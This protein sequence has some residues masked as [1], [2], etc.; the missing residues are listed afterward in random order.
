MKK[1]LKHKIHR[2][3]KLLGFTLAE[4]MV[5]LGIVSFALVSGAGILS[6]AL[7]TS[8]T[9]R[10]KTA[11]IGIANEFVELYRN[12]P[13]DQ[14]GTTTGWPPGSIPTSQNISRSGLTFTASTRVDY[15]DDPF[16]GNAAG[17]IVG[18]PRD[19]TPNDYK[20]TEIKILSGSKI[21]TTLT[22]IIAPRGLESAPN[23]G[24]LL[25]QVFNASGQPVPE[26]TV[27]IA[28]SATTPLVN[29]ANTTD[30][31]G[32]LS[33]LSLP[34]S[35]Q[36][37]RI[38]VTKS[39]YTSDGTEQANGNGYTP[40]KPDLSIMIGEVTEAS[41]TID[42]TSS[43]VVKTV[44]QQCQSVSNKAFRL[45]SKKLRGSNPD[46]PKYDRNHD[47]GSNG[48]AALSDLE[49]DQY[50][51]E[52]NGAG[53]D[54]IAGKNPSV[55]QLPPGISQ[56]LTLV[57][58]PHSPHSL[59]MTVNDV[60]TGLPLTDASVTISNNND[61]P[62]TLITG[63][64][65]FIQADWSEGGNQALFSN[66]N[67]YWTKDQNIDDIATAGIL[68]LSKSTES[69]AYEESFASID[70]RDDGATTAAWDGSGI[71]ALPQNSGLYET[72]A[73]AQT[74]K[75]NSANGWV[76]N[77][78]VEATETL[79]GGTIRYSLSTDGGINFE[80]VNLDELHA[81]VLRGSDLRLRIELETPDTISTP[82]V[83]EV[84]VAYVLEQYQTPGTLESSTFDAGSQ[85]V[86]QGIQWDPANQIAEAGVSSVKFQVAANND[87]AAWNFLGPDGTNNSFYDAS[88]A[89]LLAALD[90][91]Q[92]LRYKAIL[93]TADER[94]SPTLSS[95]AI[96]YTSG[97]TPPGQVFFSGLRNDSYLI[98]ITK[99]GYLPYT[100]T[101]DVQSQTEQ[102]IPLTPEP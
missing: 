56:E 43:L 90:N 2:A 41:F 32:N 47:T 93:A 57:L 64:G 67:K 49:W 16:D 70:R 18:K 23:T 7:K 4:S 73:A 84:R 22:T 33:I 42:Q 35:L 26:A 29:I 34:P 87:N 55:I 81:F 15:I 52:F 68:T 71:I 82:S 79:N 76:A 31:D 11:A 39:G 99:T 74:I 80:Q 66:P 85:S 40:A 94:Y 63:R 13:Y 24:S 101:I 61:D 88:G 1:Y 45:K 102:M 54:D 3:K 44:N 89:G 59:L 48:L 30:I 75:I 53:F 69:F 17:T 5:T 14:V 36:N 91:N 58:A 28:N 8:A 38:T 86:F 92:Y 27:Q 20:R 60:H 19:T 50:D 100:T 96:G 83:D 37:Y 78:T 6:I 72:P 95:A 10:A 9:A 97:C 51:L 12:L 21:L 98:E 25:L 77:A 65:F 62:A 46:T